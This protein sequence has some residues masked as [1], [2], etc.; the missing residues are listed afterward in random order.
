MDTKKKFELFPKRY[1]FFPYIFLVYVLLPI[2]QVM[3][4]NGIKQL[5]GILL[6]LVF[7]LAYRQLYCH[8]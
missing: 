3:Q 2:I 6:V 7:L 5:I 4:E 8:M 1:G